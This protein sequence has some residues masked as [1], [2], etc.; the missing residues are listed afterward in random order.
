MPGGAIPCPALR[1]RGAGGREVKLT[2]AEL[3]HQALLEQWRGAMDLIGPGP[4]SP[5]FTDAAASVRDLE[6]TGDWADLGSGAGFPGIALAARWPD[7]HVL[8]VES[9]SKRGVFL[10]QVLAAAKLTNATVH[11][12]RTEKLADGS[13]DG[14]ISRAYKPPADYL[15]DAARL[16]R[17]RG[18]AVLLLGDATP[19]PELDS[20]WEELS[21][22]R[23]RV[24]SGW[25]QRIVLRRG[26]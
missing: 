11:R 23:Y 10:D 7:A 17:P 25:R 6:A 9:R 14:I 15:V 19:A 1:S 24:G 3:A 5:H 8:L 21:T 13:F 16:L 18:R 4:S 22:L 20:C 12:G 26:G 2:D